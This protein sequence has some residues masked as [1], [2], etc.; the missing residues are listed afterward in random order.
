VQKWKQR[1]SFLSLQ[2]ST[3]TM[4]VEKDS[5]KLGM[6]EGRFE[7]NCG[8]NGENMDE[9]CEFCGKIKIFGKDLSGK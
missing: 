5:E 8:G 7:R 9:S 2:P 6:K 4:E 1:A 3:S